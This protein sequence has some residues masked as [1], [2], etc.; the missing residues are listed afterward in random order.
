MLNTCLYLLKKYRC[1][2]VHL[3]SY[4]WKHSFIVRKTNTAYFIPKQKEKQSYGPSED[5]LG[6]CCSFAVYVLLI[7]ED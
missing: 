4:I 3:L 5:T 6:I 7:R 2:S 1:N